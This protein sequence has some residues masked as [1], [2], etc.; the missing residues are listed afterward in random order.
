MSYSE[1]LVYTPMR[2]NLPQAPSLLRGRAHCAE[3]ATAGVVRISLFPICAIDKADWTK[4]LV[5]AETHR[6]RSNHKYSK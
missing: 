4:R 6:F 1:S 3:H 2:V 5:I